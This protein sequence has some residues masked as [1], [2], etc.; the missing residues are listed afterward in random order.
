MSER[1]SLKWLM[2][3]IQGIIEDIMDGI[4]SI[5]ASIGGIVDRMRVNT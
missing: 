2:E 1:F 4:E 3:G 5:V